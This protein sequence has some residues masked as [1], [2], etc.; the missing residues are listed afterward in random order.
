MDC[1]FT[2]IHILSIGLFINSSVPPSAIV[3]KNINQCQTNWHIRNANKPYEE[4]YYLKEAIFFLNK[5]TFH[6]I[7]Q[8]LNQPSVK[9]LF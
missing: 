9:G 2:Q 5:S 7:Y 3:T 1:D 8:V 6:S 4:L